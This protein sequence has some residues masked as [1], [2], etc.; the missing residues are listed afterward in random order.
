MKGVILTCGI[1]G[2]G[3]SYYCKSLESFLANLGFQSTVLC[4]DDNQVSKGNT[5]LPYICVSKID[6]HKKK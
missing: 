1:P 3:K 4:F 5:L 2:A 6:Y